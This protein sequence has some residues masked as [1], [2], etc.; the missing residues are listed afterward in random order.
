MEFK[1]FKSDSNGYVVHLKLY[2]GND[3][4]IHSDQGQAYAVVKCLMEESNLLNKC[5]HL[6]TDNFYT[7]PVLAEFLLEKKTLLTGTIRG[8]SRGLPQ[9]G[10]TERLAVRE[11]Q[12]WR[13]GEM[14]FVSFQEKK[15]Q[16]KPV[17]LLSTAH[18]AEVKEQTIWGN[19]K[20]KPSP[21]FYYNKFMGCVDLSDKQ[22]CHLASERST[23]RYW[24]KIFQNLVDTCILNSWIIYNLH[25]KAK[26]KPEMPRDKF[27]IPVVRALTGRARRADPEAAAPVRHAPTDPCARKHSPWNSPSSQKGERLLC[28]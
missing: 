15:S 27:V 13:K 4:D 3:F 18:N 2:V 1:I 16:T 5:Y 7:K 12:F 24:I 26:A 10:R 6:V 22:I 20:K 9:V 23:M 21:I 28:V 8:N 11:S 19:I 14:L 17:L 25:L